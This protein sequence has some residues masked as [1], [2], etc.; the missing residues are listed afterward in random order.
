M[1]DKEFER[2]LK[3]LRLVRIERQKRLYEQARRERKA[4]GTPKAERADLKSVQCEFES[5]AEDKDAK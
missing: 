3:E 4:S 2:I 1:T 5:R